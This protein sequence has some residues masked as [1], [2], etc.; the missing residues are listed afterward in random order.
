MGARTSRGES[1]ALKRQHSIESC[2]SRI[3]ARLSQRTRSCFKP[4]ELSARRLHQPRLSSET[5]N[6][7]CDWIGSHG[8]L[9]RS[10]NSQAV[11]S[12]HQ[13]IRN[14]AGFPVL[15]FQRTI[16]TRNTVSDCAC[17]FRA[18]GI[19][20]LLLT[21][22]HSSFLH[23]DDSCEVLGG[24]E[25]EGPPLLLVRPRL[26]DGDFAGFPRHCCSRCPDAS[27]SFYPLL[28]RTRLLEARFCRIVLVLHRGPQNLIAGMYEGADLARDWQEA[29]GLVQA[30]QACTTDSKNAPSVQASPCP[31][32]CPLSASMNHGGP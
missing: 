22:F 20:G 3:D 23:P 12:A 29:K 17:Q 5:R 11:Q 14:Q 21:P 15:V 9:L 4:T 32:P 1:E 30:N 2:E 6:R 7:V 16:W 28:R 13:S 18:A 10:V 31:C 19:T 27:K 8:S 24:G 26:G 25:E